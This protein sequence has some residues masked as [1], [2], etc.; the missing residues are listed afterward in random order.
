MYG[1]LLFLSARRASMWMSFISHSISIITVELFSPP[2]SKCMKFDIIIWSNHWWKSPGES[3]KN[4][5]QF[6]NNAYYWQ[7]LGAGFHYRTQILPTRG[8]IP[9]FH[10]LAQLS[11]LNTAAKLGRFWIF[12]SC[13]I[14]LAF[15]CPSRGS[16]FWVRSSVAHGAL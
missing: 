7:A 2:P 6:L 9:F 14:H 13:K 4:M 1:I 11:M 10:S 3:I 12:P 5:G 8:S 15:L 16:S